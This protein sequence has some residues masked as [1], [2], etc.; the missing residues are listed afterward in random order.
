[1]RMLVVF[2]IVLLSSTTRTTSRFPMNPITMTKVK[3]IGTTIGTT[4][5]KTARCSWSA[6]ASDLLELFIF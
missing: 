1:M 2:L 4:I 5:I 6:S 3:R